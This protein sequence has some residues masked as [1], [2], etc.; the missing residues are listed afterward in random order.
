M[1]VNNAAIS[2]DRNVIKKGT[3]SILKYK[4]LAIEIPRTWNVK[5]EVMPTIRGENGAIKNHSEH[6]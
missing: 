3:E 4:D 5:T 1:H 6:T 2:E